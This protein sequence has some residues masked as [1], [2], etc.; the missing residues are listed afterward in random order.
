[1]Q[2]ELLLG[3][4]AIAR[5]A[6]EAGCKIVSSYPGTPSTEVTENCAKYPEL[7][8]EWATNEKVAAEVAVGAS[9]GGARALCCM[10]H[11]GL[12]V[13]A[14]PLYTAS[15]TGVLG[16]LVINVAD[17]PGMHSS[18]NEQDSRFHA[19]AAL[20]PML[21]P[22]DSQE[23]LDF[24]KAAFAL[25]EQFDAPVLLR[26]TTRIAHARSLTVLS[27]REKVPVREYEKNPMK[28]VMMPGMARA[29][30]LI[31]EQRMA[32]LSEYVNT[33]AL[34]R[35]EMRGA[36]IGIIT[37]GICYQY[38]R[39]ALPDAS[40]LKLG[41]VN[42]LPAKWIR[43]F[44]EKV[45]RLIIIEELEPI[46]E[47]QV[48]AMG[49][50]CEGKQLTGH[51]GEMSVN[52]IRAILGESVPAHQEP[53]LQ[54]PAR[55]P[56]MCAGCPHRGPFTI[57]SKLKMHVMGDIGCYTLGALAPL[58][59]LDASLCMGASVGMAQGISRAQGDAFGKKTVAVIG[60]STFL[61]SGVPSLISA[62]YNKSPIT[63]MVLDN[64]IT[65]MTGHQPNPASGKDIHG[66]PAEALNIEALCLAC[67]VKRV[68]VVD[69]FDMAGLESAI[70]EETGADE[71]SV[72]IA[73]RPCALLDKRTVNPPYQI[74]SGKCRSC[75][76]C[77][78]MGCPAIEKG[79]SGLWI[80]PAQC[81]GC[82]LCEQTCKFGAI[83][84]A[85]E[86]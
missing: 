6:W 54:T 68:R 64:R 20:V 80:N 13:A 57:L 56:I 10:K 19:R 76:A 41:V 26:T 2:R 67:G 81:V 82:G 85:G 49:I 24:T 12:N 38:V 55:P 23:C 17:D 78:K 58:S 45:K 70:K 73:R 37:S 44:S 69:A 46:I 35:E 60:D 39:E 15:Y 77:M 8:T 66:N 83:R 28:Y 32:D 62:A 18:Q 86:Q 7:Y 42:P 52:K 27:E 47:E 30:H 5:G 22:S 29:R 61:H 25:S 16:G 84:K 53:P 50:A 72:I 14:D 51:Q 31:V 48:R 1:M 3:N 33:C 34:N 75:M 59:A 79:T 4:E 74:D 9:F 36:D 21:E 11:V 63:L 71:P 40:V 65:G 43:A